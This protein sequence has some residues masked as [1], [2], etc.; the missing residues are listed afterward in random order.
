MKNLDLSVL[1]N[2]SP[3]TTASELNAQYEQ[4]IADAK[5][6]DLAA[7]VNPIASESQGASKLPVIPIVVIVVTK[8]DECEEFVSWNA[9]ADW[10][11]DECDKEFYDMYR[12]ADPDKR[13]GCDGYLEWFEYVVTK[14][15]VEREVQ[16]KGW[17]IERKPV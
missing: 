9:F 15:D 4:I 8:G 5:R 1:P 10:A 2:L 12:N 3:K 14:E 6:A 13:R 16:D 11:R 7:V 17:K